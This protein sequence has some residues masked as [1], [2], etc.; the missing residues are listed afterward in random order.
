[1]LRD[2]HTNQLKRLLPRG[3]EHCGQLSTQLLYPLHRI[4]ENTFTGKH[5]LKF[6][7]WHI[8]IRPSSAASGA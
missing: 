8:Q 6:W 3:Q 2:K 1:M 4:Q 7:T 5:D